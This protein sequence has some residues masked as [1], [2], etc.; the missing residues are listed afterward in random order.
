MPHIFLF[1]SYL[2]HFFDLFLISIF[3]LVFYYFLESILYCASNQK[4]KFYVLL[5]YNLIF[6]YFPFFIVKTINLFLDNILK[7]NLLFL[8]I[9][10]GIKFIW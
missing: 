7:R 4:R 9:L 8:K 2:F 10:E 5:F 6:I 3:F 1:D